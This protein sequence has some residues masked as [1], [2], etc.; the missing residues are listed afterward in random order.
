MLI[1]TPREHKII[2]T[3]TDIIK[4]FI[5]LFDYVNTYNRKIENNDRK[6]QKIRIYLT[7]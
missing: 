5:D 1:D 3:T 4:L 2:I 6:V 7:D